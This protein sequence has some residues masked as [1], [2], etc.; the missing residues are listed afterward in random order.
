DVEA[1]NG[2]IVVKQVISPSPADS[3]GLDPGD[4]I[5]SV[6]KQSVKGRPL[7]Q[8]IDALSGLPGTTVE[9][10]VLKP[11]DKERTLVLQREFV[12]VPAL[13]YELL[14]NQFGYF[15]IVYFHRDSAT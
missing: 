13:S 3:A 15:R 2:R 12:K 1:E 6:D 8:S 4:I 9:L 5:T 14:E 7:Q 10:S 11:G